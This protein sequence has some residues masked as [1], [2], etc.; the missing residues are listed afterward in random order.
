MNVASAEVEVGFR[1][2]KVEGLITLRTVLF[3]SLHL[4]QLQEH[5]DWDEV[6]DAEKASKLYSLS[7]SEE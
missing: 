4:R 7:D 6:D 2:M 1:M 5:P 3:V